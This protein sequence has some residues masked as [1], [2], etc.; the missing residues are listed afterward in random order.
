MNSELPVDRFT[1]K[2]RN[3][4]IIGPAAVVL[5]LP[6]LVHGPMLEGHDT[7]EHLN[8]ARHFSEQFWAGER[9]PH[10]LAGMN[11]GLG[12]P[13]FFVFPP[14]PSYVYTLLEPLGRVCHF[15]AFQHGRISSPAWLWDLCISLAHT[16]A[17]RRVA[18]VGA[19]LYM[20]MPYHLTVDYYRRTAL[21]ECWAFVWMPLVLYFSAR[22]MRQERIYLV[23]LT[24][25]YAF[26]I[27]SH[28]ISVLI[29]S[30][31]W[32]APAYAWRAAQ[33]AS[34]RAPKYF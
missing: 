3:L 6:M 15:N 14:F 2:I 1:L 31:I 24:V 21:P 7:T 28:L 8:F 33:D 5:A 10:W 32:L 20:L 30:F 4:S 16:M 23:G 26:L 11:H 18:V 27:L 17:S 13:T 12:S 34:R 22:A 29:F 19:I 25:A 9:Y